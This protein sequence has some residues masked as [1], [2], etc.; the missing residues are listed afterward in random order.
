MI[1][2]TS[3]GAD[4]AMPR[5][6]FQDMSPRR[7]ALSARPLEQDIRLPLFVAAPVG[8]L[9]LA[10]SV[11]LV[12]PDRRGILLESPQPQLRIGLHRLPEQRLADAGVLAFRPHIE[13]I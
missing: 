5:A 9:D 12:E 4:R 1:L 8:A 11:R 7:D 3:S 10:K 6:A 13:M 2:A